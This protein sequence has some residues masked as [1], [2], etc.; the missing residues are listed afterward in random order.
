MT[1]GRRDGDKRNTQI[2]PDFITMHEKISSSYKKVAEENGAL[3]APVGYAFAIVLGQD[4]ALFRKLYKSDGSHPS[5]EGAYL[6]ACVLWGTLTG[7]NPS[8]IRWN[9]SLNSRQA[10]VL[11]DAATKAVRKNKG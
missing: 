9:G 6:A 2:Y 3:L 1:W 7:K 5:S 11:R 10:K 4:K 8:T